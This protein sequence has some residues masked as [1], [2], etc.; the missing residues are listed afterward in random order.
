[1]TSHM[2]N[3]RLFLYA[4]PWKSPG[5]CQCA[6]LPP[7]RVTKKFLEIKSKNFFLHSSISGHPRSLTV[8]QKHLHKHAVLTQSPPLA[9]IYAAQ[10]PFPVSF[11]YNDNLPGLQDSFAGAPGKIWALKY[12]A[13][14]SGY[15]VWCF[16]ESKGLGATELLPTGCNKKGQLQHSLY[17]PEV[18]NRSQPSLATCFTVFSEEFL[19][20]D[21]LHLFIFSWF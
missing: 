17:L 16:A 21:T 13:S 18:S 12:P 8:E 19:L 15:C 4:W 6:C 20:S 10:A 7:R 14:P 9:K 2:L 5:A 3:L 1:M 11:T